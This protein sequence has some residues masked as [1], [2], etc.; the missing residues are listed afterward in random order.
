MQQDGNKIM[1]DEIDDFENLLPELVKVIIDATKRSLE[2]SIPCV[3][4]RVIGRTKV[5]VKPLIKIVAQNGESMERAIIEGLPVF[6]AGAGNKF[7]SFPVAVGDIGWLD[8]CD[9]DISLFLQSYDDVEPPSNRMHTFS[10]ARFVPDIMTNI[11]IAEEDASSIVIQTRDGSVKIA[12][13]D[14]EIRINN[15]DVSLVVTG[16]AVT[17]IAPDGFNL[18]GFT[19]DASGAAVSPVSLTAPSVVA[20]GKELADHNHPAGTPPANTGPNN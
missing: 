10:D 1:T 8:A 19:I 11:T 9:R 7:M 6:T 20:D 17:G 4:T 2:V 5:D 14:G 16:S 12:L 15:N 18:N 3:V 13:D